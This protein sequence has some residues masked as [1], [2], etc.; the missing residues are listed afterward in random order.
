MQKSS[1][2]RIVPCGCRLCGCVCEAHAAVSPVPLNG[3]LSRL[4][5]IHACDA[6]LRTIAHEASTLVSLA[7]FVGMVAVWALVIGG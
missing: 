3:P 7:L 6:I 1:F 5:A 2:D 4:C